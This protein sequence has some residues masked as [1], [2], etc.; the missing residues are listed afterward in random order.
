MDTEPQSTVLPTSPDL[1]SSGEH[2]PQS[3]E[4]M[5]KETRNLFNLLQQPDIFEYLRKLNHGE[6][7]TIE[8]MKQKNTTENKSGTDKRHSGVVDKD[9]Q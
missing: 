4:L 8:D 9:D 3:Q 1:Q 2:L 6:I 7:E 5:R